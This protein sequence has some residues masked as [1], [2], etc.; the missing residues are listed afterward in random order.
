MVIALIGIPDV[1]LPHT[2]V[3]TGGFVQLMLTY[4]VIAYSL[5]VSAVFLLILYRPPLTLKFGLSEKAA[6]RLERRVR[7]EL[8]EKQA[9][10]FLSVLRNDGLTIDPSALLGPIAKSWL[11]AYD[12][13]STVQEL[14]DAT[15]ADLPREKVRAYS[16][17]RDWIIRNATTGQLIREAGSQSRFARSFQG[18]RREERTLRELGIVPG[19]ILKIEHP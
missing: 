11:V 1:A 17:G 12:Q 9:E 18:K 15:W 10:Q 2:I 16:Y 19:T 13:I 5:L 14:L 6:E 7:S 4:F 3:Y 8:G